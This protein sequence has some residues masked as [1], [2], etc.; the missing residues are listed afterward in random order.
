MPDRPQDP[1]PRRWLLPFALI[2][3]GALLLL[4][5][6]GL[7]WRGE[8]AEGLLRSRLAAM[9]VEPAR[10]TVE[11][12]GLSSMRL[13][14]IALGPDEELTAD[15]IEV[16]YALL[17]GA[18]ERVRIERPRLK[19]DL[20]SGGPPLGALQPLVE[21]DGSGGATAVPA[22]AVTEGRI[23][24]A[25]PLGPA[26]MTLDGAIEGQADGALGGAFQVAGEGG[27]ARLEGGLEIAIAADGALDAALTIARGA[28]ALTAEQGGV[29]AEIGGLTGSLEAALRDGRPERIAGRLA[30]TDLGLEQARFREAALDFALAGEALEAEGSLSSEDGGLRLAFRG[31]GEELFTAPAVSLGLSVSASAR[32]AL[33]APMALPVSDGVGSLGLSLRGRLPALARYGEGAASSTAEQILAWLFGGTVEGR[34]EARLADVA[35]PERLSGLQAG[36][37]GSL[38]LADGAAAV[39]LEPGAGGTLGAFERPWLDGLGLPADLAGS[40]AGGLAFGLEPLEAL[41]AGLALRP[42][43]AAWEAVLDG[44]LTARPL[45]DGGP[46]LGL[47]LR[48]ARATLGAGLAFLDLPDLALAARGLRVAGTPV[49]ALSLEGSAFGQLGEL[50]AD[51]LL[52]AGIDSLRRDGLRLGGL[53]LELPLTATLLGGAVEAWAAAP[54]RLTLAR[55]S[56]P[57]GL[58]LAEP[59]TVTLRDGTLLSSPPGVPGTG[60]G[61]LTHDLRLSVG[62]V[63]L[64]LAREGAAALPISLRPG[65]LRLI[66]ERPNG[67]RYRGRLSLSDGEA[68][69]PSLDTAL[70]KLSAR[71]DF[72]AAFRAPKARFSTE[73][74]YLALPALA[75]EGEA[76]KEDNRI[77]F[78]AS[79]GAAGEQLA[80]QGA[81][82]S[83]SGSY[84]LDSGQASFSLSPLRLAF[85]P[86]GLQP[87]DLMPQMAELS[88]VTGAAALQ[89]DGAWSDGRLAGR[90]ALR[91]GG[92]SF[93]RGDIKVSGLDL[94]LVL[95]SL[96]PPQSRPGQRLSVQRI[97][98]ALPIEALD[99]SFR[100]LPGEPVRAAIDRLTFGL[101]GGRFQ[102]RGA[103]ID[104]AGER[105]SATIEVAAIE[106]SNL[107]GLLDVEGLGGRG[108]L[109]GALPVSV[110]GKTVTI[111]GGRLESAAPG[112]LSYRRADAGPA[113]PDQEEDAAALLQDPLELT[114]RALENFQ[115]DRLAVGVDKQA[116][117]NAA[118][119][120]ELEGKNPDLLDGY[121]FRFNINLTGDVTPVLDALER[122]L[123]LT[124]DL[125]GRSWKLQP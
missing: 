90:G 124:Q 108:Q 13:S 77:L 37:K 119:R 1:R 63:A 121:P 24:A 28:I 18:A 48:Q 62:P 123:D 65:P 93:A 66:G 72:D 109:Q 68:A 70:E 8:I 104:P 53:A 74:R 102:V 15:A 115:Y 75:L 46:E 6:A 36:A 55:L 25:T 86:G 112:V 122:G 60:G 21:G 99:A 95:D 100:L 14:G 110:D 91:L 54:G 97:D 101:A 117:G 81:Q 19:I 103:T 116:D 44:R 11:A 34:F 35:L 29:S 87:A 71:L 94:E 47:A 92:L 43:P 59:V 27:P 4:V 64:S 113:L 23:E 57:S 16:D 80:L 5:L 39:T 56:H 73:L 38:L 67:G 78:D 52:S 83:L 42:V 106:L 2:P 7:L 84:D 107:F 118:L 31:R 114:L 20:Q 105:H 69:L 51:L 120:V 96:W 111:R 17:A 98:S 10:L 41:P 85:A 32:A 40:L 82:P 79:A 50:E 89:A 12:V 26:L 49:T 76:R 30:L 33:F 3:L 125:L 22:V 58:A 45:A 88:A 61:G 9:G